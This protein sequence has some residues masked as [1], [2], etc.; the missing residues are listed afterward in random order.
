MNEHAVL[1]EIWESNLIHEVLI[2]ALVVIVIVLSLLS[3]TKPL[4]YRTENHNFVNMHA[5]PKIQ[6]SSPNNLLH[7]L[8][9]IL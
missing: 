7:K 1:N 4:M 3:I 6:Q 5:M 9:I 2:G 8:F